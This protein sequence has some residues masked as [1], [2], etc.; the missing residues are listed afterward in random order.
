MFDCDSCDH[1]WQGTT[2]WCSDLSLII[3]KKWLKTTKRIN[4]MEITSI[5]LLLLIF[6]GFYLKMMTSRQIFIP[7]NLMRFKSN[8]SWNNTRWYA[9]RNGSF[10]F[11][12][13]SFIHR[14]VWSIMILFGRKVKRLKYV[15][16]ISINLS[17]TR[18]KVN[19]N[20]NSVD[21]K[22]FPNWN[23]SHLFHVLITWQ[24]LKRADDV[25]SH[26]NNDKIV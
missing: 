3:T 26:D 4:E 7:T 19:D 17:I 21:D 22:Q 16:Q 8:D 15:Q 6:F 20:S 25:S 24:R 12:S 18:T 14:V 10:F 1:R 5:A 13:V 23:I 11:S 2:N 9:R